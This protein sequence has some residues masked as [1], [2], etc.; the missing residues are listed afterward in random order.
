MIPPAC[1]IPPDMAIVPAL[2]EEL[3]NKALTTVGAAPGAMFPEEPP[4]TIATLP[5]PPGI[6]PPN[7]G[8]VLAK[9]AVVAV[10]IVPPLTAAKPAP[11]TDAHGPRRP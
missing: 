10:P 8:T 11:A 9:L 4:S 1:R 2:F 6:T 3:C 5:N 7:T